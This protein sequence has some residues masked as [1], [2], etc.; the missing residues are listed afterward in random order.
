MRKLI[1]L[2]LALSISAPAFC[3]QQ[4]TKGD[5]QGSQYAAD[6]DSI[7]QINNE[8]Q[9]R[10]AIGYRSGASVIYDSAATIKVLAGEL[11]IPNADGSVVKYRRNTSVT[12]VS[13]LDIDTGA[14]AGTT[15]YYVWALA[16]TDATTFT[17][18]IS[19]SNSAPSGATYYR[20]LGYFYN[21]GSSNITSVGNV[22]GS[23]VNQ[24]YA[25]GTT[26][27]T[28]S[29]SSYV[30]TTDM[31]VT[32][33]GTGRPVVIEYSLSG[34]TNGAGYAL[35]IAIAKNG[36]TMSNTKTSEQGYSGVN[37]SLHTATIDY[38]T[39]GSAVTYTGRWYVSGGTGYC[40]VS[41][42]D[43][44]RIITVREL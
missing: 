18:K 44:H 28:T 16:D 24:P 3:V 2:F 10:L 35:A 25:I 43:N 26:D 31:S 17:V 15:Q 8:A 32:Y 12:S 36:S 4:W 34:I 20:L 1:A 7:Q 9:D 29:S 13:W 42:A 5:P 27:I 30:D 11:A 39:A 37:L 23:A 21:D 6:I 33:I 22:A 19:V 38:P 40:S 14:E 41:T